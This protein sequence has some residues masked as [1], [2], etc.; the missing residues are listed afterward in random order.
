MLLTGSILF[1]SVFFATDP[2]SAPKKALAQWV[3]GIVIGSST[4]L[5]RFFAPWAEGTSFAVL[6]GNTFAP[7]LDDLFTKRETNE[8]AG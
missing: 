6:V 4:V 1:V 7:L 5:I 8:N 3:Y 2:V